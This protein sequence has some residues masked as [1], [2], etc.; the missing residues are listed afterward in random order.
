METCTQYDINALNYLACYLGNHKYIH[1]KPNALI[2]IDELIEPSTR[3]RML[4]LGYSDEYLLPVNTQKIRDYC[5]HACRLNNIIDLR[6]L[7]RLN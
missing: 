6:F 7:F 1:L 3:K 2:I 5:H 4:E